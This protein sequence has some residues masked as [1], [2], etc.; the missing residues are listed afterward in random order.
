MPA[1]VDGGGVLTLILLAASCRILR[2]L[3]PPPPP[4]PPLAPPASR[5]TSWSTTLWFHSPM[6]PE[7]FP[8][9]TDRSFD[10]AN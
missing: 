5:S 4:L 3:F 8:L 10:M 7:V 1:E 9:L 6:R 2:T